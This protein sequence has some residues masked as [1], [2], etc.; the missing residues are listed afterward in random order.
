M[1]NRA[2]ITTP[3]NPVGIYVHWN[4]GIESVLGFTHAAQ[5]LGVR[6]PTS[7]PTYFLARLSQI[8]GNFF[9]GTTSVGVGLVSKLDSSDNGVWVVHNFDAIKQGKHICSLGSLTPEGRAKAEGIRDKILAQQEPIFAA[10][11][12]RISYRT[13]S[14]LYKEVL[15]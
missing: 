14:D 13:V 2:V 10:D 1:G 3:D 12:Y 15:A 9:G 8:I 7:D 6:S 11:G 5:A 4:G